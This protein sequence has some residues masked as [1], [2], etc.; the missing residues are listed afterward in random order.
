MTGAFDLKKV[1]G[2]VLLHLL[3]REI[4]FPRAFMWRCLRRLGK[5]KTSI[6]PRFPAELVDLAALPLWV[7][8]N[9][10]GKLGRWKS[11]SA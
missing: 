6:D 2:P 5:F 10:K 7:Y 3:Q 1:T 11:S 8:V 4:R 9:L